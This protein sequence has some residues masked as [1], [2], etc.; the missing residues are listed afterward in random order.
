MAAIEPVPPTS[1]A[2]SLIRRYGLTFYW[3]AF[4]GYTLEAARHPGLVALDA[5]VPYSWDGVVATW[6]VLGVATVILHAILRP[7]TFRRSWGRLAGALGYALVLTALAL[8]TFVT[9]MPGYV[10][11]PAYFAAVTLLGLV[12]LALVLALARRRPTREPPTSAY[13]RPNAIRAIGRTWV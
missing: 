2:A 13:P 1:P 12:L 3:L 6:A 10:Y 5:Q 4:A 7:R 11:V 8:V 9:D